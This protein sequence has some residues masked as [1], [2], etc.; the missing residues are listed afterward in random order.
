VRDF[1]SAKRPFEANP[2]TPAG[3]SPVLGENPPHHTESSTMRTRILGKVSHLVLSRFTAQL[4]SSHL[5]ARLFI[6]RFRSGL[7]I[8]ACCAAASSCPLCIDAGKN[9][10][11][12]FQRHPSGVLQE[13]HIGIGDA[14]TDPE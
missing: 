11:H 7:S 14:I 13:R 1:S 3:S 2:A 5:D 6:A 4:I 12:I 8:V 9:E 10:D